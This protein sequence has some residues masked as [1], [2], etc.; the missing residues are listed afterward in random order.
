LVFSVVIIQDNSGMELI[1]FSDSTLTAGT[2]I[3]LRANSTLFD[4]GPNT[5]EPHSTHFLQW[6]TG[7]PTQ[8]GNNLNYWVYSHTVFAPNATGREVEVRFSVDPSGYMTGVKVGVLLVA[9]VPTVSFYSTDTFQGEILA[10]SFTY[11]LGVPTG[12]F[13]QPASGRS[14]LHGLQNMSMVLYR[15]SAHGLETSFMFVYNG[16]EIS[17]VSYNYV[18]GASVN[19]VCLAFNCQSGSY[20]EG[21]GCRACSANCGS[22]TSPQLCTACDEGYSLLVDGSCANTAE[23]TTT[24]LFIGIGGA[25]GSVVLIAIVIFMYCCICRK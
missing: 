15:D 6:I 4:F 11:N 25:L 1:I 13:G 23:D 21:Q 5:S 22:C 14:C 7:F 16:S 3:S 12:T 8:S 9:N 24:S 19:T 18:L 20:Y 2:N 17:G 10:G